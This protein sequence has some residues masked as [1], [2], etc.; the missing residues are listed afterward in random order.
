MYA[1]ICRD[2]VT[3]VQLITLLRKTPSRWHVLAEVECEKRLGDV[4]SCFILYWMSNRFTLSLCASDL[5]PGTEYGFGISAMKGSNQS[6]PATMNARTGEWITIFTPLSKKWWSN[7]CTWDTLNNYTRV[8]SF[9]TGRMTHQSLSIAT[10]PLREHSPGTRKLSRNHV[11]TTGTRSK[12]SYRDIILPHKMSLLEDG[13]FRKVYL[14]FGLQR[15]DN[16]VRPHTGN[17]LF[18]PQPFSVNSR[19]SS[20]EQHTVIRQTNSM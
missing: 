16:C 15:W 11:S 10:F 8:L 18:Q 5:L 13:Y 19:N 2:L 3:D 9:T 14:N 12:L 20:M 4:S 6:T 7:S 17:I 1:W